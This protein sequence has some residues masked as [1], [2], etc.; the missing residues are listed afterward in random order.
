VP[1]GGAPSLAQLIGQ[2]LVVRMQGTAPSASLL[3]RAR[4]GQI[5]GVIVHQ[6]NLN[7]AAA[8]RSLTSR[9]QQAAAAGGQPPLLIGVDQEG[10]P[11]KTVSWIPPTRSPGQMGA[12]GSARTA[13][14]Q[15]EQTGAGLAGLGI[16]TD[17]GPVDDVPASTGSFL[18]RQGRTWSFDAHATGRLAGWFAL[19]LGQRGVLAT[20]KHFPGL[21]FATRDTD[22]SV[23]RIAATRGRLAPGLRPFKTAIADH[24]P[25]IMLSN[26][27][28]TAYD[29]GSAAG[30]SPAV[31]TTLLRR[32]LGFKGV[33]ITDSL[34]GAAH[35]RHIPATPLA[36]RAAAA[37]T[38]LLL[39]TASESGSRGVYDSLLRAAAHGKIS[40]G[41]LL[42]SYQRILRLKRSLVQ[43]GRERFFDLAAAAG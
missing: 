5:G 13:H 28:Y 8:L 24:V 1:G 21:G 39:L 10:G 25:L 19:G 33:T 6:D 43:P 11:V 29:P 18:F 22:T 42:A 15:G 20:A 41:G 12:L 30:W 27:V 14:L 3:Q 31:G 32:T 17:F 16:N 38:D 26:A 23:V 36:I 7:S 40:R 35:S 37:G 9:L 2:K 4:L 34:D